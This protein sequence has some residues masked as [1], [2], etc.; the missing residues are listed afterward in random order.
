V[1]LI[2]I[3]VQ[4]LKSNECQLNVRNHLQFNHFFSTEHF[5]IVL[6]GSR[7]LIIIAYF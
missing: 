3:Y 1:T 7:M 4:F 5:P 6:F 2:S